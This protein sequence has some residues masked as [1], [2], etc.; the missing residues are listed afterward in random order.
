MTPRSDNV[1]MDLHLLADMARFL[2]SHRAGGYLVGGAVRDTLLGNPSCNI[3]IVVEGLKP[4]VLARFLKRRHGFSR[5]VVFKRSD[6]VFTND[7]ATEVEISPMRGG[8]ADDALERDFTVNCLY[9][10]LSS[11]LRAITRKS[12]L[13]PTGMGLRDLRAKRLRAYPDR[14]TPFASDPLRLMRAV[15]FRATLGLKL[16]RD[17][18]EGMGRMAYLISRPS[19]E[20]VRDELIRI[21]LSGRVR[22]SFALMREVGL[23]EMVLPEVAVTAGFDQGSPYHAY[24]LLTHTMK[25]TASTKPVL[26]LRLAGLLH[27]IGK[28][29][30]QRRKGR[31]FVYY[32]HEK[33]SAD[34]ARAILTRLRFPARVTDDVVFLIKNHMVNYSRS[35]TD[36][37][38]RRFMRKMNGRLREVLDL[39]EADRKAHAPDARM[40][41]PVRELRERIVRVAAEMEANKV[42]FEAP[43]DGV[44]IMEILGIGPGPEVGR[45]KEYLCQEVLRRGRPVSRAE[46]ERLV[47]YWGKDLDPKRLG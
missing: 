23:L 27:D 38:V 39:A 26:E 20:R 35:W 5:A 30:A 8:L 43:L 3:D 14:F 4:L 36:A 46:A 10:K 18:R 44:R 1:R 41:A 34:G 28:V 22:S 15:R 16:D 25:A 19:A 37:A 47:R 42:S 33:I 29:S 17:L 13:D 9:V 45:A 40:G 21:L 2:S 24:D 31:R 6:T 11:G 12:V 32:G 7:G